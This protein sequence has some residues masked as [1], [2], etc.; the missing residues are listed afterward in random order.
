MEKVWHYL[1][2]PQ[3][4]VIHTYMGQGRRGTH[5]LNADYGTRPYFRARYRKGIRR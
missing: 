2:L 4:N 1:G 5:H 3:A